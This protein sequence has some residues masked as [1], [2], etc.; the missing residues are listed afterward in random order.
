MGVA[1]LESGDG[2]GMAA[3]SRVRLVALH[4]GD[5]KIQGAINGGLGAMMGGEEMFNGFGLMDFRVSNIKT[6]IQ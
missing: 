5:P 4:S 1:I 3:G 6:R 2:R